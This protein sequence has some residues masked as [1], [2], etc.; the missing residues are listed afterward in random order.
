L[1]SYFNRNE[2]LCFLNLLLTFIYF[3]DIQLESDSKIGFIHKKFWF[4]FLYDL[5]LGFIQWN[6]TLDNKRFIKFWLNYIWYNA[7]NIMWCRLLSNVCTK[8]WES[9]FLVLICD[10][11]DFIPH[12]STLEFLKLWIPFTKTW[13]I[14]SKSQN[15]S[16]EE[17]EKISDLKS[18]F[19]A[20]VKLELIYFNRVIQSNILFESHILGF[21]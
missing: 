11:L 7:H 12:F 20:F 5:R 9:I 10:C 21:T 14:S 19:Y 4:E 2:L 15:K 6:Y 1:L 8:Y 3:V 16:N 17:N 13:S 18:R